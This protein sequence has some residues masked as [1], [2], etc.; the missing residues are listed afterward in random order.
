[1]V[2]CADSSFGI[3]EVDEHNAGHKGLKLLSILLSA[4][5][6]ESANG[7]AMISPVGA[8]NLGTSSCAFGEL[9]SCL[10]RFGSAV[11]EERVLELSRADL[12]KLF[13]QIAH[14]FAKE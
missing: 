13:G 10:D 6:R 4:G 14:G 11:A 7:L 9:E 2:D 1:M 12:G 8:D 5:G 3:G